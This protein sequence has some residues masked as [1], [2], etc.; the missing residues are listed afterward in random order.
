MLEILPDALLALAILAILFG[1]AC[2][3]NT[4]S[5]WLGRRR[6]RREEMAYRAA[7]TKNAASQPMSAQSNGEANSSLEQSFQ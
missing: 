3:L 5:D 7:M 4:C 1:W 6:D 2:M